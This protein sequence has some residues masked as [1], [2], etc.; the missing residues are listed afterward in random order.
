MVQLRFL[1][2][3]LLCFSMGIIDVSSFFSLDGVIGT[4]EYT[5]VDPF[6]LKVMVM[7]PFKIIEQF[8]F[9]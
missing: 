8:F 5:M 1:F 3:A 7:N 4:E 6:F 9:D 2:L